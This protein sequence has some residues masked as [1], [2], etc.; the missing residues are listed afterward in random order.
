[1]GCGRDRQAAAVPPA[2]DGPPPPA[3]P[4]PAAAPAAPPGYAPSATPAHPSPLGAFLA[5]TAKGDW[6]AALKIA[7]WPTLLLLVLACLL[8]IFSSDD[9]DKAGI[10]WGVRMRIALAL[11]L[12]GVGGGV[13]LA[14]NVTGGL[15]EWGT[16]LAGEASLSMVPLVVTV[17]WVAALMVA[18]RRVT[19]ARPATGVPGTDVAGTHV[20]GSDVPETVLRVALLCGAG[21]LALGLLAQPSYAGVELSSSPWLALLWSF[22][23]AAVA[24]GTVLAGTR[25]QAWLAARPAVRSAVGALRTALLALVI[26]VLVAGVVTFVTLLAEMDDIE[27]GDVVALLVLLPNLGAMALAMAWGAPVN[28]EWNL[29]DIPFLESGRQSVGYSELADLGGSWALFG[30]IVAGLAGALL[31]GLLAVRRSADRREQLL[32]A[33]F[34]VVLL[35]LLVLAAGA[36]V[37]A[38]FH[39]G[40]G[41]G[42]G[43]GYDGGY[44][45][46]GYGSRGGYGGE[47]YGAHAE[48]TAGGGETLLFAL[49]W[50]FGAVLLAP[51]LLMIVGRGGPSALAAPAAPYGAPAAATGGYGYPSAHA[52]PAP[53][54]AT[55]LT[56]PATPA[57]PAPAATPT[58]T[59]TAPDLPPV[60]LGHPAPLPGAT[61]PPAAPE[62]PRK[63]RGVVKWVSLALAA[64]LIGG[65]A[66]AGALYFKNRQATDDDKADKPAVARSRQPSGGNGP[67][68]APS[69]TGTPSPTPTA[70]P[71]AG[72]TDG[73]SPGADLPEGFVRKD[74][75]MGFSVGVRDGWQRVQKGTQTDYKAPTGVE[76]LRIGVIADAPQSS[77]DNFLTLEK[78]AKKRTNYQRSELTRNTFQNSAGARWEFTYVN[79]SGNTIHAVDQAYVAAD[80]TEYSIYHE[81]LEKDWDAATDQVFSTAL[82]TWSVSTDVD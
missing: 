11:L 56:P 76:Y 16:G 33:G 68:P 62:E 73:S 52:H 10:G 46:G 69:P 67:S 28:A 12:Q 65:G 21:T 8:G 80:G 24:A 15:G 51:Y 44:G 25:A 50:T 19:G 32:A 29:P 59:P 5:R 6:P 64:F 47:S 3:G 55:P 17:L 57:T 22:L 2:P 70:D 43:D 72:P 45:Y 53:P 23:L 63:G 77:Y 42:S 58:P 18:A 60:Q 14:G 61:P 13:T 35:V 81:C 39:E 78:G 31:V 49:L 38:V 41:Y 7:V 48:L 74:D 71:T 36:S 4:P 9:M 82:K 40:G 1:M 37:S 34:F 79:D 27:G 75:S 20:P 66:T 30:V 54:E 26:V